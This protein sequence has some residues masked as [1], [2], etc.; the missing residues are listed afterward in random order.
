[1]FYTNLD[2]E[3]WFELIK[4]RLMIGLIIVVVVSGF[5]CLSEMRYLA[6]G[7]TLQAKVERAERVTYRD[8]SG[9]TMVKFEVRYRFAD[10]KVADGKGDRVE[11]DSV[12]SEDEIPGGGQGV[13]VQYI[14]G[15]RE[16][17]RLAG[18]SNALAC[19]PF[20]GAMGVLAVLTAKFWK[21]YKEYER[22]KAAW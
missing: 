9:S 5:F 13:W 20:V 10:A 15:V 14:P 17:S 2:D 3:S 19:M 22:R 8:R 4:F 1:M 7:R 11:M 6:F 18:N 16:R 21:D 12:G